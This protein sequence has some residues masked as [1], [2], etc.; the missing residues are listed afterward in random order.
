[1]QRSSPEQSTEQRLALRE[2]RS[3]IIQGATW[4]YE[5]LIARATAAGA[6]DDEIDAVANQA[7]QSLLTGAEEPITPQQLARTKLAGVRD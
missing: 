4:C 2:L 6:T 3:A 1:M 7:F 5:S